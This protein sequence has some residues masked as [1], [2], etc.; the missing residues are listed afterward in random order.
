MKIDNSKEL[1][2]I[3]RVQ[4]GI[5]KNYNNDKNNE[6]QSLSNFTEITKKNIIIEN[7]TKIVYSSNSLSNDYIILQN[8]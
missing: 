4:I 3:N 8:V 6:L 5:S 1:D 7:I 2:G